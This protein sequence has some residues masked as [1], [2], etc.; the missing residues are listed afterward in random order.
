[1]TARSL[2]IDH[3][4][5]I[6]AETSP[7]LAGLTTGL[8]A[9]QLQTA[10]NPA[11]W[12]ANQVL[13]HLRSCADVWG[14]CIARII[15]QDAPVILAVHPR[16]WIKKTNYLDQEFQPSL[17]AFTAQRSELLAVLAPLAPAAWSQTATIIGEGKPNVRSVL[18]YARRLA[19]HEPPHINQ[20]ERIVENLA[21]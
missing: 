4:L 7:L 5:S 6:L 21:R 19:L 11:E 10:P 16:N 15:A 13:A 20:I 14:D 3:I 12:S 18:S 9:G 2:S 1:M 8:S 17:H